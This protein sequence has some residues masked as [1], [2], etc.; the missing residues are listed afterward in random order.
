MQIR[1]S[2]VSEDYGREGQ[3]TVEEA[4]KAKRQL[5]SGNAPFELCYVRGRI[6][7]RSFWRAATEDT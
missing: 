3:V 6:V 5:S 1:C 4:G 2:N 7:N